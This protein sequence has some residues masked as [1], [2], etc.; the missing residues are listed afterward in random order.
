MQQLGMSKYYKAINAFSSVDEDNIHV[1]I[2]ATIAAELWTRHPSIHFQALGPSSDTKIPGQG[3]VTQA[4]ITFKFA[5]TVLYCEKQQDLY[6]V[7]TIQINSGACIVRVTDP[8]NSGH[9]KTAY[10]LDTQW[11][12]AFPGFPEILYDALD[13]IL[14]E[15]VPGPEKE[16]SEALPYLFEVRK[17]STPADHHSPLRHLTRDFGTDV[18]RTLCGQKMDRTDVKTILPSEE[19]L[20]D[21]QYCYNCRNSKVYRERRGES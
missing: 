6:H 3:A 20:R 10:L 15:A 9:N 13:P 7:G 11:P 12:L 2:A 18:V 5:R 17:R 21:G 4:A 8:A 14:D 19:Y 16:Q 1:A